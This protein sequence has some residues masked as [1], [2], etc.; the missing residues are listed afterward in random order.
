MATTFTGTSPG[1]TYKDLLHFNNSNAGVTGSLQ[2]LNDGNGATTALQVSTTGIGSTGTITATGAVTGS[3]LS[4]TNTGDQ[5]ITLTGNVTG[6]GTGSFAT[7][8]AAKAITLGMLADGT[9]GE[10]I[11]WDSSGVAAAVATGTAGQVLT[12][13]GAGVAPTMQTLDIAVSELADG[14]DGELITWDAS[15]NAAT[16]GAGTSA[17]V[18]TSNGAGAAP[19]FQAAA[20]GGAL[21]FVSTTTASTS[22]SID[23]TGIDSSAEIWILEISNYTTSVDN[24]AISIRTSTDGGSSYDSGAG[25]YRYTHHSRSDAGSVSGGQSTSATAIA[26]TSGVGNAAGF[27]GNLTVKIYNPSGTTHTVISWISAW[28]ASGG[29]VFTGSGMGKRVS[30]ADVDAIQF[31]P[32]SGTIDTGEFTLYKV[33]NS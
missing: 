31:I 16:V 6:S 18:L 4:G 1:L 32:G 5:T 29:S 26:T 25:N 11:T 22:S 28:T 27:G 12:S 30:A 21:T 19:T 7:T 9:D 3:N 14:T 15:G 20:A 23:I 10:L 13:G 17:Q 8:V 24:D 2:A 33:A